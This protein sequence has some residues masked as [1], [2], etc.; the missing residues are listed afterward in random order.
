MFQ[1]PNQNEVLRLST[2]REKIGKKIRFT[3]YDKRGNPIDEKTG[4][5]DSVSSDGYIA[6]CGKSKYIVS[7]NDYIDIF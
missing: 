4:V 5:I 2:E 6:T 3:I 1:Y 7:F